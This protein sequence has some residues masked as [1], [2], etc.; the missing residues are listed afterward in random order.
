MK[1]AALVMTLLFAAAAQA[2]DF[3]YVLTRR[4][5][6]TISGNV[7]VDVIERMH[8]RWPGDFLWV[9]RRG[10]EYV[11]RD[12]DVIA[13]AR[14]VFADVQALQPEYA[15][16]RVDLQPLEQRHAALEVQLNRLGN[17]LSTLRDEVERRQRE[18]RMAALQIQ[19]S[20]L[21]NEM[22][23]LHQQHQRIERRENQLVRAAE[24]K[25]R[26]IVDRAIARGAA[27]PLRNS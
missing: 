14:A 10:V 11:I 23:P 21:E 26:A 12:P 19:M 8:D 18:R 4:D 7:N 24:E 3:Q 16:V 27:V 22:R 2:A 5:R 13:E 25:L 1:R 15:R 9:H 17:E 20:S 6:G